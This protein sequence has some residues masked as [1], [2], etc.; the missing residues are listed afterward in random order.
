MA[1]SKWTY[2][3]IHTEALKYVLREDFKK[4]SNTAYKAARK[5]DIYEK[6]CTHMPSTKVTRSNTELRNIALQYLTKKEF[7]KGNE[8]AYKTANAR[9]ILNNIC[10][11][12]T[13]LRNSWTKELVIQA[14]AQYST[15]TKF[16]KN[17]NG[18]YQWANRHGCLE[19]CCSHMCI[20]HKK[21]TDTELFVEASQ[22]QYRGDFQNYSKAAYLYAY[23]LGK[24]ES[25]CTHMGTKP[26]GLNVHKPMYMY[27]ISITTLDNSLPK[28]W[29]VGITKHC[30]ILMRFKKECSKLATKIDVIKTWYFSTG[31]E[32]L[33]AEAN[34]INTYSDYKYY[35]ESPLKVTGA[36]EMFTI[37]IL[38]K[39]TNE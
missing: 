22:Y 18:A 2:E 26:S 39:D 35:G 31:R 29:K 27:F 9:G 34:A 16:Q 33:D 36:T 6:V 20:L 28:V 37:N 8:S 17:N 25:I 7:V 15:R 13:P 38:E 32:A 19:E 5:L 24:L 3:A 14:A 21:W 10:G 12:M 30:D 23:R 1:K 4:G 11:H